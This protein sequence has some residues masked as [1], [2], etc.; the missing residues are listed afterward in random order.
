MR[1]GAATAGTSSTLV[2]SGSATGSTATGMVTITVMGVAGT[3]SA[4]AGRGAEAA[5][6]TGRGASGG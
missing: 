6:A 3:S 2:P 5:A 4:Q 1:S